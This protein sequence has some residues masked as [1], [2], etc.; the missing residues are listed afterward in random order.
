MAHTMSSKKPKQEPRKAFD[1]ASRYRRDTIVVEIPDPVD[2]HDTGLRIEI[3]SM[4]SPEAQAA[5][6]AVRATLTIVDNEVTVSESDADR[7]L[8]EQTIAVT[9]RWWAEPDS[10]DGIVIDGVVVPCTPDT[11]RSVY[12]DP[13]TSWVQTFVLS[14]YLD[15]SRFFGASKA[16]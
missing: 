4:Q 8:L 1:L 15:V 3:G 16:A 13:R 9:K 14:R 5:R 12:T 6:E 11:V 10:P 2:G 7:S